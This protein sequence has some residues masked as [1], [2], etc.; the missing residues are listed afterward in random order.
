ME[1]QIKVADLRQELTAVIQAVK[2]ENVTFVVEV[3]GRPQV[4]IVDI[5]Q[6]RLFQQYQERRRKEFFEELDRIA[7][8]DAAHNADL[9]EEEVLALIDE[10]RQ[11]VWDEQQ[12]RRRGS[13]RKLQ[14]SREIN[15]P[16]VQNPC[17]I[18]HSL[19][20]GEF[21]PLFYQTGLAT[22]LND[23]RNQF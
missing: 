3:S 11:E 1:R 13:S 22:E 10:V 4:A 18:V 12:A 21:F 23:G 2:E 20:G 9:S 6:Y 19:Q 16:T 14:A 5:D 15:L 17:E 8:I 7:T